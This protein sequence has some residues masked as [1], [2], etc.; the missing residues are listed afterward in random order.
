VT[1]LPQS[2][3]G[4]RNEALWGPQ[5]EQA[6]GLQHVARVQEKER[7]WGNGPPR[8]GRAQT[9]LK[10]VHAAFGNPGALSPSAPW[11]DRAFQFLGE[12]AQAGES[13]L[14]PD[15][16]PTEACPVQPA[17]SDALGVCGFVLSF[18]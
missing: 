4:R 2:G 10:M 9:P 8:R 11:L 17:G 5:T 12:A 1:G 6:P 3:L 14:H 7:S 16:S 15:P 13:A 18:W